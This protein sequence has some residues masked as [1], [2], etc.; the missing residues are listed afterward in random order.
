[1]EHWN[2]KELAS[3]SGWREEGDFIDEIDAKVLFD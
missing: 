3:F 1:V 2:F